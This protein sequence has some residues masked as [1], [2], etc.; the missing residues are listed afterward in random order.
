VEY[1]PSISYFPSMESYA[2]VENTLQSLSKGAVLDILDSLGESFGRQIRIESA[3]DGG[4]SPGA[5]VIVGWDQDRFEFA[6]E[7]KTSGRPRELDDAIRMSRRWAAQTGRLPMVIVPF[8][9]EARMERLMEAGVS[10]LD[11]CGNGLVVVPGRL[12]LRRTGQPNRYP[13]S[14]PT[15]FAYSGVTSLV[16]RV[17]LRRPE[18]ESVNAVR[19]EVTAAGGVVAL[20]TVSKALT[21]MR[22]D[23]IIERASGRISLLQTDA[24][25]DALADGFR[26]P[27]ITR[28]KHGRTNLALPELFRRVVGADAPGS[29]RAQLVISGRSS[30]GRYAAGLRDDPVTLYTDN[31][32]AFCAR[33]GGD[34]T[35]TDRFPDLTVMETDD[36]GV[37]FDHRVDGDGSIVASPVQVYLELSSAGDKRDREIAGEVRSGILRTH[38][39]SEE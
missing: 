21:R 9:D 26:P 28:V 23:L 1:Y 19:E 6:A 38:G 18:F 29:P 33:L 31:L 5:G 11:L 25:L 14:R 8:L 2:M 7:V 12:L 36:P 27:R 17:F 32:D 10:G 35:A 24:L 22:D 20:S 34:W 3:R 15:R 16:P 13:D 39:R 4:A 30:A 37:F